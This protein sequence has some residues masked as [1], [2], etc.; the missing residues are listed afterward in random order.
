MKVNALRLA[1]RDLETKVE[2]AKRIE[3]KVRVDIR[4]RVTVKRD[5]SKRFHVMRASSL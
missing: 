4:V 1:W 5:K 3:E 2:E